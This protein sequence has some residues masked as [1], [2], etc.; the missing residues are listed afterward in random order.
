M[1]EKLITRWGTSSV[2][3]T[4]TPVVRMVGKIQFQTMTGVEVE[5][6]AI[7]SALNQMA[8]AFR[9]LAD[10]VEEDDASRAAG[11]TVKEVGRE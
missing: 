9:A 5:L 11:V 7:P 10:R 8:D 1:V 4:G 6:F 3:S 2:E